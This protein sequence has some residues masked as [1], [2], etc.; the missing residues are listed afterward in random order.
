MFSQAEYGDI[1]KLYAWVGVINIVYMFG[2]E[3]AFFRFA[4]KPNADTKRIFNLAQTNVLVTS[5]TLTLIFIAFANPIGSSLKI[6]NPT[7]ITWLALTMLIDAA[8]AIPFARLRL[9]KKALLFASAKIINVLILI[10]LNYYFLKLNYNPEVGIGY[11]FMANLIANAVF[12]LFFIKTLITWRPAWDKSISPEMLRYAY[13]V[14]ITGVAGMIN[15][16]FSRTMLDWWLPENFYKGL[17]SKEAGG[18]FGACYKFAMFMNLGIQAFR[19][20]AE[21]FFFSNAHDKKSPELFSK[22]NHYFVITCCLVLLGV[23]INVDLLKHLIGEEFW[24]GLSIVPVLLLAYLFLGI[25]YNMSIWFKLTDKT[26]YG[27][28]ITVIGAVI[29]IAGNYI[30]IPIYGFMGSAV[31]ALLCYSFMAIICYWLGQRNYPIPYTVSRD[32]GYI[33]FT[34]SIL[35]VVN[36]IVIDNQWLSL[37]FHMMV[38]IVFLGFIYLVERKTFGK[39]IG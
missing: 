36:R 22:I 27:T 29:T 39:P 32:V 2:M 12:I 10:G 25:Y 19:Y 38:I 30:L 13:P 6:S 8:V 3:T 1:T 34:Y 33:I 17:T 7:F 18:V 16:M 31:A 15:E 11:V 37:G 35:S 4:T 9:E 21:P 23:S 28:V 5:I 26:Y 20:A 24:G 14:M